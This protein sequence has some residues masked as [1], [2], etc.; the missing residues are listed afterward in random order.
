MGRKY[1][2]EHFDIH[3]GGVDHIP[4]HHENEI[5]QCKGSFGHNPANF[6]MHCEFLLVD[7]GKM[8]KSLGNIYRIKDLQDKGIE[9]LAFK[10][11]CYSSHYRNKLNFTFEGAKSSQIAL[12]RLREGYIKN[13][14]SDNNV[15]DSIVAEYENRFHEA[16]NDDLN[17]PV[18]MGVVWEIIRNEIKSKKFAKLLE[19]LDEVL[20]LDLINSRQYLQQK[21]EVPE[22][23]K[24]LI[25]KRNIAKAEKNWEVADKIREEI[26]L[27][28]YIIK[29]TKN[30]VEVDKI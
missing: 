29:D 12:N 16:I 19:K 2:G 25:E 1:L 5:A 7:G 28:G 13:L 30:G 21:V 18:A 15:D 6:W 26:K 3:T 14:E 27:K 24:E 10:L 11:F 22:E 4:I 8:S 23:I 9:P 17:M 20:G